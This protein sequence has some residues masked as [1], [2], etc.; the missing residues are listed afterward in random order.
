MKYN[1]YSLWKEASERSNKAQQLERWKHQCFSLGKQPPAMD[2][3]HRGT[4]RHSLGGR[5][6]RVE[7]LIH[8][9]LPNQ[10]ATSQIHHENVPPQHIQWWQNL[11]WQYLLAYLVLQNQWSPIYDVWAILTSIRSLLADPNPNS[12]ANS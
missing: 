5:I 9:R 10:A 12:P 6:V 7:A 8:T 11:S 1:E 4:W 2:S 3:L